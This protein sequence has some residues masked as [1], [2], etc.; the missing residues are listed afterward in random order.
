I[1]DM[2]CMRDCVSDYLVAHA[3]AY[4]IGKGNEC[5]AAIPRGKERERINQL[6]DQMFMELKK[7]GFF[8]ERTLKPDLEDEA[9]LQQLLSN[10]DQENIG[11]PVI[12]SW[13]DSGQMMFG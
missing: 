4:F 8:H 2:L 7:V 6:F 9:K 1:K 5:F 12:L 13:D 11:K 10:E 3:D